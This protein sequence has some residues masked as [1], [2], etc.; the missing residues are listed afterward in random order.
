MISTWCDPWPRL[1]WVPG[2][3]CSMRET[4]C[5]RQPHAC[6]SCSGTTNHQDWKHWLQRAMWTQLFGL[7]VVG[8]SYSLHFLQGEESS[9][10]GQKPQQSVC[11]AGLRHSGEVI[12]PY[13]INARIFK[14]KT[15]PQIQPLARGQ[16][17]SLTFE[18]QCL[19]RD[20]KPP[21]CY[22]QKL[23]CLNIYRIPS[24][25]FFL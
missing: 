23:E 2:S 13:Y 10:L 21:K 11:P 7:T 18:R 16:S 15:K 12:P 22:E 3:S 14:S 8:H 9:S 1:C 17:S 20:K 4:L 6:A 25:T 24:A 19:K 5:P